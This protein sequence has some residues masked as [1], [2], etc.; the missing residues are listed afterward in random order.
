M[1]KR[2]YV[3]RKHVDFFIKDHEKSY[4]ST[5]YFILILES[6]IADLENFSEANK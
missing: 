6:S 5:E 1:T 2:Y 4:N 3:T